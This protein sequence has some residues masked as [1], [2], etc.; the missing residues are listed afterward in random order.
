M[1][2]AA[3]DYPAGEFRVSDA[4]RDRALS[5]LADA[6]QAGRITAGELDQRSGQILGA[7][8]G[9]ELT[10]PLADLPLDRP[11]A[12]GGTAP[13]R[14]RR[15]FASRISFAAAIAAFCFATAA[16]GHALTF[17][18]RPS[19]QQLELLRQIAASHGLPAPPTIPLSPGFDWVGV[20][21]PGAIAVSLV[22]L[23]IYLR[24]RLSRAHQ[25][26]RGQPRSRTR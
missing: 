21:A 14:D 23:I 16:V 24:V 20:I 18:L 9:R 22:M 3:R 1:D 12:A 8:T 26:G 2:R 19:R 6:F 10:A 4:D 11:R 25:A 5:E 13:D 17:Y 15:V 7:R